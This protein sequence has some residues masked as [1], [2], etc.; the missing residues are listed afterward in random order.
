V[1][2]S[3]PSVPWKG[4]NLALALSMLSVSAVALGWLRTSRAEIKSLPHEELPRQVTLFAIS[5]DSKQMAIDPRLASIKS[6]LEK[7]IP[8][9]GFKLLDAQS[10]RV[11]TGESVAC[12]LSNGYRAETILIRPVD[13]DGKVQLRCEL[14]C[15]DVRQFSTLVR[16]PLN[17]LFFLEQLL[18]DHSQLLVG[19]GAR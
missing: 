8:Q 9:H 7:L 5:A 10:K 18:P 13:E 2:R 16:A 1:A 17:Q 15:N 12:E 4:I 11:T 19:V 6:Q 14:F 3:R